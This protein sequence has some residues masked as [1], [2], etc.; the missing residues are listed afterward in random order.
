MP[1]GLIYLDD[2]FIGEILPRVYG[3]TAGIA[4]YDKEVPFNA[5][6]RILEN[7]GKIL[8]KI[9]YSNPKFNA[10]FSDV[11]LDNFIVLNN[12]VLAIDSSSMKIYDSKGIVNFYLYQ[13]G[14]MDIAKYNID[15]YGDIIPDKNTDIY[16]YIMMILKFLSGS[17]LYILDVDHYNEYLNRLIDNGFDSSL[18][19][20]FSSIYDEK[21]DNIN[22]LIY[23]NTL[24]DLDAKKLS[25]ARK[26]F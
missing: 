1:M 20:S 6:I 22:P 3:E 17:D 2:L 15:S 8:Y 24:Y 26:I 7:I 18:I 13:L 14:T 21:I 12:D 25:M 10:C 5:K 23:L 9:Q 4:I 16:C 19:H 11:H